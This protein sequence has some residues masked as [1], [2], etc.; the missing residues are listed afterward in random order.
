MLEYQSDD[1]RHAPIKCISLGGILDVLQSD[2]EEIKAIVDHIGL[3]LS[4]A[5][6]M[7]QY[8]KQLLISIKNIINSFK[9]E[10]LCVNN[11]AIKSVQLYMN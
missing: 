10:V 6:S 7:S 11:N 3:G 4:F 5:H 1:P 8:N 2:D 9:N